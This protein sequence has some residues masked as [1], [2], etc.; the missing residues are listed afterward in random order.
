MRG[1]KSR[2]KDHAHVVLE[3]IMRPTSNPR[4]RFGLILV[5][6]DYILVY[7]KNILEKQNIQKP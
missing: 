7:N 6:F 3:N 5:L 2:V 4:E 1:K